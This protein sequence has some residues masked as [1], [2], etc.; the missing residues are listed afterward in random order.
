LQN[1]N[2]QDLSDIDEESERESII[3]LRRNRGRSRSVDKGSRRLSDLS[4]GSLSRGR[5]GN[6]IER[7]RSQSAPRTPT[8]IN[9]ILQ[10]NSDPYDEGSPPLEDRLVVQYSR[11]QDDYY[12]E[13]MK[14]QVD[15]YK[16]VGSLNEFKEFAKSKFNELQKEENSM[17]EY[18]DTLIS[19]VTTLEDKLQT[20][21]SNVKTHYGDQF[22]KVHND[23]RAL[24]EAKRALEDDIQ[25][26]KNELF[27][28]IKTA[29]DESSKILRAEIRSVND[30]LSESI[31]DVDSQLTVTRDEM[32]GKLTEYNGKLEKTS[33]DGAELWTFLN[34][35]VLSEINLIN[36]KL[37]LATS[38]IS[39]LK[40]RK[41]SLSFLSLLSIFMAL[42]LG[43]VLAD[44][45]QFDAASTLDDIFTRLSL[46]WF[47]LQ[48]FFQT[49]R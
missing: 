44:F 13:V 33:N 24:T 16:Q 29:N 48:R 11:K 10:E 39:E 40:S 8:P 22:K 45:S 38:E 5:G 36:R 27:E 34:D 18:R 46:S 25:S 37:A 49:R 41:R 4:S 26:V 28:D 17:K 12:G 9:D 7:R 20:L 14:N 3:S 35:D 15:L 30:D 43:S 1:H 31:K 42:L 23:T 21:G 19:R 32:G 6:G 2:E 47:W